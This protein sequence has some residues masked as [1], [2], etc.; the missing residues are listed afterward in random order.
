MSLSE[1]KVVDKN[2]TLKPPKG[3]TLTGTRGE[4]PLIVLEYELKHSLLT[5]S[6]G[7][8]LKFSRVSHVDYVSIFLNDQ[9]REV[10]RTFR[11]SNCEPERVPY[12]EE[13]GIY[14]SGGN[15]HVAES[16]TPIVDGLR[17]WWTEFKKRF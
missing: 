15:G 4:G 3:L 2:E 17:R 7:T 16:P 6:P 13:S 9:G 11:T 10:L 12:P 1:L 14:W 8:I 5:T